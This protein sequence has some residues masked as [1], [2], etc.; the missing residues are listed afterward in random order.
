MKILL[1]VLLSLIA[2]SVNAAQTTELEKPVL[3]SF[4]SENSILLEDKEIDESKPTDINK[5]VYRDSTGQV[6]LKVTDTDTGTGTNTSFDKYTQKM[7]DDRYGGKSL[8]EYL[9]M[10]EL[11]NKKEQE[12]QLEFE[13]QLAKKPNARIG[14]TKN[15]ILNQSNWGKPDDINTTIDAYG[16]FEQWIYGSDQYLYFTNGKLTTIQQ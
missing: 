13:R 15:Q 8:A 11:E 3:V 4:A 7:N 2:I 10:L 9:N 12:K 1:G 16:T 14:M 5:Y 6:R